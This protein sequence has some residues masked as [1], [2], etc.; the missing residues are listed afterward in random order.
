LIERKPVPDPRKLIGLVVVAG[1]LAAAGCGGD[2]NGGGEAPD[3]YPPPTTTVSTETN[4][5]IANDFPKA[6]PKE[7]AAVCKSVSIV[8]PVQTRKLIE[9]D[10]RADHRQ[11]GGDIGVVVGLLMERCFPPGGG[12]QA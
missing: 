8:G 12:S 10:P 7:F 9:A 1:A 3:F 11:D 2:S 5:K 6:S 4:Q